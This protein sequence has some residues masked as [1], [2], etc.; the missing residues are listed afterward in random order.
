MLGNRGVR[1]HADDRAEPG[2][3]L[4]WAA[5]LPALPSTT[6]EAGSAEHFP[7]H[8]L[9]PS[10]LHHGPLAPPLHPKL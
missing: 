4:R 8:P 5:P 9:T 10:F 3:E 2:L 7:L 6:P 1:G